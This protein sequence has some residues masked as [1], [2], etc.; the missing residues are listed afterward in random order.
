MN[1]L[2]LKGFTA[3]FDGDQMNFHVPASDKAVSEAIEKMMPSK[4]LISTTDLRTPR[5]VPSMEMTLG[6]AKLTAPAS[7]A[8]PKVFITA[9][10]A[11]RAYRRGEIGAN[12]PVSILRR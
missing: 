10:D 8:K 6:L 11:I 9:S 1:P 2:V 5:H 4:N 7:K 3:D 12:D